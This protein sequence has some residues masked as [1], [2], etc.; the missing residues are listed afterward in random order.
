MFILVLYGALV[1]VRAIPALTYY[2]TDYAKSTPEQHLQTCITNTKSAIANDD[3]LLSPEEKQNPEKYCSEL[4]SRVVTTLIVN[5]FTS[6]IIDYIGGL[7]TF[8]LNNLYGY[9]LFV[10]TLF[11]SYVLASIKKKAGYSLIEYGVLGIACLFFLQQESASHNS[12]PSDM[13]TII[14]F[15]LGIATPA[16]IGSWI[17][18]ALAKKTVPALKKSPAKKAA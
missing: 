6:P 18:F 14:S 11:Y 2:V 9:I 12:I 1:I 13:L 4:Q 10:G 7:M 8:F 3:R 17:G 16:A 15:A 5:P